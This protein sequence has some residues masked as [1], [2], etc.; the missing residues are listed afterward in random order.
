M[1][2][3]KTIGSPIARDLHSHGN[4]RGGNWQKGLGAN[5]GAL[6]GH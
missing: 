6:K 4:E 2:D 1:K 3:E 5:T